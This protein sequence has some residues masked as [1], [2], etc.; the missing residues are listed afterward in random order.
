MNPKHREGS[1]NLKYGKE[2]RP[3]PKVLFTQIPGNDNVEQHEKNQSGSFGKKTPNCLFGDFILPD[4]F[5][6]T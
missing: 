1:D 3:L 4:F 5:Y 6:H 2:K